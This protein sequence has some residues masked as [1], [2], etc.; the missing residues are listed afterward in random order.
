MRPL[1]QKNQMAKAKRKKKGLIIFSIIVVAGI[2]AAVV[3]SLHKKDPPIPVETEK[4]V[5]RNL[6]EKV[7]ANG[8]IEP[9]LQV[10]ISP[11]VSGEIIELAVKEGQPVKK[12]DFLL[13]IKPDDYLA[14]SNSAA[15]SFH[16]AEAN[17]ETSAANLEKA[18][19][20]YERSSGLFK[21]KLISDSDYLTAKTTYDVAKT[22]LAGAAESVAMAKASLDTASADLKK[23]TIYSPLD[24]TVTKLNSQLGERVVGTAMM[25]GTEIMTIADLNAMEARVD[26]GEVDVVL[27]KTCQKAHLEVD[28]FKDR[29]F[30]GFVTDVANSA[31]NNDT[32]STATSSSSSTTDATKFQVKIRVADKEHFLPGMSVTAEIETR[33]RTNVISVPIQSVTT[34]LPATNGV[35]NL[36]VSGAPT[37]ATNVVSGNNTNGAASKPAEAPKPVEIVFVLDGDHVKNV[38]VKRGI[39][40]DNYTEIT[41]GLKEGDVVVSGGYKAINRDLDDGKK[42]VKTDAATLAKAKTP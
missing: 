12:G 24:G 41:D 30:E 22:T 6:T 14:A 42:A 7:V 17:K 32:S 36:V 28:S 39:S 33:S 35:T 10:K 13:K 21:A 3:A 8:K 23:T 18:R 15:A 19:L 31:N 25:A 38:P 27:I 16:L 4:V 11:E 26:V 40:D 2:G 34:R 9:V 37:V 29:K 1:P 5:R 20:E